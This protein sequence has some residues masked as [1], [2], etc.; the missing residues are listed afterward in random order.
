MFNLDKSSKTGRI[1]VSKRDESNEIDFFYYRR[2]T[3]KSHRSGG[4]H[5]R[6]N[7]RFPL[8]TCVNDCFCKCI[9]LY[10]AFIQTNRPEEAI[11]D[12]YNKRKPDY[13]A[14]LRELTQ[15]EWDSYTPS[16]IWKD[17][18]THLQRRHAYV[19]QGVSEKTEQIW[20][21]SQLRKAVEVMNSLVQIDYLG[22]YDVE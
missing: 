22:T 15:K 5:L 12:S 20:N 8:L 9:C 3:S 7:Q 2:K 14:L 18:K 21:R 16:Y 17:K 1:W 6:K 4:S 11:W 10:I 13:T 19:I